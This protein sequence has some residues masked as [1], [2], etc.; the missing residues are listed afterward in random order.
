MRFF[1]FLSFYK[2]LCCED[3]FEMHQHVDA[4]KMATHN[5]CLYKEVDKNYIDYNLKTTELLDCAL[6]GIACGNYCICSTL[7]EQTNFYSYFP[8]SSISHKL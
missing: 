5:I 2:S 3:S 8:L 4:I 1:F 6:I 7:R